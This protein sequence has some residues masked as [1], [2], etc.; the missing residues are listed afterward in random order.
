MS[1]AVPR[2]PSLDPKEKVLAVKTEDHPLEYLD[3]EEV[4]PDGQY[5]AGPI[6]VWDRGVVTYLEGPAEEELAR[7]KLHVELYVELHGMKL[8][9]RWTFVKLAKGETGAEWLF[10]KKQD[11]HA[12]ASRKIVDELPRSVLSG[13]T[14]EELTKREEIARAYLDRA[15]ALGAARQDVV[16]ELFAAEECPLVEARTAEE[17]SPRTSVI[18][19]AELDGVRVLAL[20]DGDVIGWLRWQGGAPERIEALYP[21]VVRA[22][23]ALPVS[24]IALDGELGT[25]DATGHPSLPLLAQ[26]VARIAKGETHR[27]VTETPVV[28]VVN[29]T[30]ALEDA[31][32]R[33]LP[34]EARRELVAHDAAARGRIARGHCA[35]GR[36]GTRARVLRLARD[37]ARR[38]QGQGLALLAA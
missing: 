12:D 27:A 33:S 28:F 22:L 34:I 23:R 25:F 4:I 14:V 26:R 17:G 3:F 13:L 38:R 32:T 2:G 1:F 10:F 18:Y 20:R 5:G 9:G 11:E 24:R 7:G 35:R 6:I 15:V 8:R 36:R 37:R 29:D 30:L 19:D 31:D 16:G 21:D